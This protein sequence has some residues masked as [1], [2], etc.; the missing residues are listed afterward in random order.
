M[1]SLL[2]VYMDQITKFH[3]SLFAKKEEKKTVYTST[4]KAEISLGIKENKLV[5]EN[6]TQSTLIH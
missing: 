2:T 4:E 5:S 6:N 1:Q 3:R